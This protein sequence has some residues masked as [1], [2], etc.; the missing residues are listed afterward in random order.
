MEEAIGR[1]SGGIRSIGS[2]MN[3]DGLSV[4]EIMR[5]KRLVNVM[6]KEERKNNI[7]IRRVRIP[8]E[9][10]EDKNGYAE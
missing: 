2:G 3:K 8:R 6:D 1:Q 4:E 5:V 9:K 7:I 10:E